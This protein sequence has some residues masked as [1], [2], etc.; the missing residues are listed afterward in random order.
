MNASFP[1]KTVLTSPRLLSWGAKICGV[2]LFSVWLVLVLAEF[3]G[4]HFQLPNWGMVLQGIALMVVFGAYLLSAKRPLTGSLLAVLA[5]IGFFVTTFVGTGA[6]PP[7]AALWFAM[8]AVLTLAAW[9][10]S[11]ARRRL[12]RRRLIV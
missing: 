2:I 10:F 8:P 7:M 12:R 6:W 4:N 11:R 5:L 3:F 1:A 9:I